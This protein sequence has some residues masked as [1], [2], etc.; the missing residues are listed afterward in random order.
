MTTGGAAGTY[1][2]G[3]ASPFCYK[4]CSCAKSLWSPLQRKAFGSQWSWGEVAVVFPLMAAFV[5]YYICVFASGTDSAGETGPL[6]SYWV[7]VG[8][9]LSAHNSLLGWMIGVPFERRT[10][11][12]W[13]FM[14]VAMGGGVAQFV[15][16]LLE[17]QNK[18]RLGGV[19]PSSI[20]AC[21]HGR[22][23][24]TSIVLRRD[25]CTTHGCGT[26]SYSV[27]QQRLTTDSLL[28]QARC[29]TGS[30]L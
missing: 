20:L 9:Q 13:L 23:V 14:R 26:K 6:L 27:H 7:A 11:Y 1:K 28:C 4:Y 17:L 30:T 12:H 2:P 21:R 16:A 24:S 22:W 19:L 15:L 3:E 25:R 8:L 29:C 18:R 10:G 5:A